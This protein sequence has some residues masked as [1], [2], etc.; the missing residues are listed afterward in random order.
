MIN[1]IKN[2]AYGSSIMAVAL[3]RF[4]QS[5]VHKKLNNPSWFKIIKK[6]SVNS[7]LIREEETEK[8]Y[9]QSYA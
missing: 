7:Y 1:D 2:I 4:S 8:V 5:A 9:Q 3:T 6:L